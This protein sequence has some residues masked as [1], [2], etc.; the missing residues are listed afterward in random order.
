MSDSD[1]LVHVRFAPNGD[2]T[3]IGERPGSTPAQR[4]F[5]YLTEKAGEQFQ[6]LSGGRGLFRVQPELLAQFKTA[7][8][9]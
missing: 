3:E 1:V 9:A 7:V 2:V 5:N 8:G 6:P 4:W